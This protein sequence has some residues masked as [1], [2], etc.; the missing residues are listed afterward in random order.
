MSAPVFYSNA[1]L[2]TSLA[3][4]SSEANA[5][6]LFI[7]DGVTDIVTIYGASADVNNTT[8]TIESLIAA[9]VSSAL[10]SYDSSS[11]NTIVI[12][13]KSTADHK[14]HPDSYSF[15]VTATNNANANLTTSLYLSVKITAITGFEPVFTTTSTQY[16]NDGDKLDLFQ[17]TADEPVTFALETTGTDDSKFSLTTYGWLSLDDFATWNTKTSYSI[18]VIATATYVN[19]DSTGTITSLKTTKTFIIEV[20]NGAPTFL[21]YADGEVTTDDGKDYKQT[22]SYYLQVTDKLKVLSFIQTT[23]N[24]A[25]GIYVTDN[26]LFT[27]GGA[28]S[29]YFSVSPT[30]SGTVGK[31]ATLTLTNA[32]SYQTKNQYNLTIVAT[33]GSSRQTTHAIVVNV[34]SDLTTPDVSFAKAG[35]STYADAVAADA[36][37][38]PPVTA[39]NITFTIM[40]TTNSGDE[41]F[42]VTAVE[43]VTFALTFKDSRY[44]DYTLTQTTTKT[45]T[46]SSKV[47]LSANTSRTDTLIVVATDSSSNYTTTSIDIKIKDSTNPV[48]T[49][50]S[51]DVDYGLNNYTSLEAIEITFTADEAIQTSST[52]ATFAEANF[53]LTNCTIKAS[54]GT[55]T[56]T[57]AT[58][59]IIPTANG[60]VKVSLPA[61][62]VTDQA[63]GNG[64]D[65]VEFTFNYDNEHKTLT[66]DGDETV[67]LSVGETYV[68]SG[69]TSSNGYSVAITSNV[70]T[71]YA[72][73]YTVSYY[74]TSNAGVVTTV[75]RHVY[76]INGIDFILGN[77]NRSST[78]SALTLM[79]KAPT[80][81]TA[82]DLPTV[83]IQ[84]PAK[85]FSDIFWVSLPTRITSNTDT[86]QPAEFYFED[87]DVKYVTVSDNFPIVEDLSTTNISKNIAQRV[88][89]A[90]GTY[91]GNINEIAET[92]QTITKAL[93]R[94]WAYEKFRTEGQT[95]LISNLSVIESEV[96]TKLTSE[97]TGSF[98]SGIRSQLAGAASK[99]NTDVTTSNFPRVF[100]SQLFYGD[101]S[102]LTSSEILATNNKEAD[103][104]SSVYEHYRLKVKAGDSLLFKTTID[105]VTSSGLE[106]FPVGIKMKF[107]Y[108][109]SDGL[110]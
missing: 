61:D 68:D 45:A 34:V 71:L 87:S 27:L 39:S 51:P 7:E 15:K 80:D 1:T 8:Y 21:P 105:G 74:I 53:T 12:R 63:N 86:V 95:G 64:N 28:D 89:N 60:V 82:D 77:L 90:D 40:D 38:S 96:N 48:I 18:S 69:A 67:Y 49:V 16:I 36:D 104:A 102:R 91:S 42:T 44:S 70:T 101:S 9:D 62:T 78:S 79:S 17:F 88:R 41:I 22:E 100:M 32:A 20:Q 65:L 58:F 6:S 59:T 37:A 110:Q 47:G 83:V 24:L 29:S 93:L 73:S 108:P 50:A 11:S 35:D 52:T 66:L 72:G 23:T 33:D 4:Y 54:S 57:T 3:T 10:V 109:E 46:I 94:R 107:T 85:D 55:Y 99:D 81:N 98:V 92:D 30:T 31:T 106:S 97:D 13:L 14:T 43:A 76:V 25:T 103:A 84:V 26:S 5:Y 56:S 75:V 2:T 19:K